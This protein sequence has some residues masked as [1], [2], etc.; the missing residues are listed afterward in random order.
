MIQPCFK[1]QGV[2]L[3]RPQTTVSRL[4]FLSGSSFIGIRTSF[5]CIQLS[6]LSLSLALILGLA[7]VNKSYAQ[8]PLMLSPDAQ[9]LKLEAEQCQSLVRQAINA[10]ADADTDTVPSLWAVR[11]QLVQPYKMACYHH[12]GFLAFMGAAELYTGHLADAQDTL[13]RTLMLNPVH[14]QALMDYAQALNAM[15]QPLTAYDLNQQLLQRDD[16]PAEVRRQL[17]QRQKL[18]SER[19]QRTDFQLSAAWGYDS[20][21]NTAPDLSDLTLTDG[22]NTTLPLD[23]SSQPI[24]GQVVNLDASIKHMRLHKTGIRYWQAGFYTRTGIEDQMDTGNLR[25]DHQQLDLLYKSVTTAPQ[26]K[27]TSQTNQHLAW[28]I[29]AKQFWYNRSSLYQSLELQLEARQPLASQCHADLELQFSR[30]HYPQDHRQDAME[31]RVQPSIQC[32]LTPR[33]QLYTQAG[34]AFNKA[35]SQREG[36]DRWLADLLVSLQYIEGARLWSLTTRHSNTW[37]QQGYSPVLD[38]NNPREVSNTQFSGQVR[39]KITS[40][41]DAELSLQRSIQQSN[42]ELFDYNATRINLGIDWRF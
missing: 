37:D 34:I 41:L 20:N 36:R 24:S 6:T 12:A 8:A 5:R 30:Q 40:R 19:L 38:S 28:G 18:W 1:D 23:R 21:L 31:Y 9:P 3:F 11:Y 13:E 7:G 29:A 25:H 10:S 27:A 35:L 2:S 14:G 17:E 32:L 26:M 15:G 16:L 33:L 42:I 22:L 4:S 39:Q